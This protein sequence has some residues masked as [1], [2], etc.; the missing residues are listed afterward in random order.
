MSRHNFV[1]AQRGSHK[2]V[3]FLVESLLHID[4][5]KRF[6]FF[7]GTPKAKPHL[8]PL[9]TVFYGVARQIGSGKARG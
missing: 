4:V 3:V 2:P 6:V 1:H 8:V 5:K 7:Q 9:E